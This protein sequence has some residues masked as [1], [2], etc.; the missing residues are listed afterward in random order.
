MTSPGIDPETVRLVAQCLNHYATPGPSTHILLHL[1][2]FIFNL[3]RF[4]LDV[5]SHPCSQYTEAPFTATPLAHRPLWSFSA[6]SAHTFVILHTVPRDIPSRP[7]VPET[8]GSVFLQN[9][10]ITTMTRRCI[11]EDLIFRF[12]S[13]QVKRMWI[14]IFLNLE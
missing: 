1:Y 2:L 14:E 12:F 6:V 3:F 4:N 7:P 13:H 10:G 5:I 11:P 9:L 8:E